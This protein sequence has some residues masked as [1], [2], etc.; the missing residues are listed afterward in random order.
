MALGRDRCRASVGAVHLPSFGIRGHLGELTDKP[1]HSL[2]GQL[3]FTWGHW[4]W[5]TGTPTVRWHLGWWAVRGGSQE[6]GQL[7]R[8]Q[9]RGREGAGSLGLDREQ[10]KVGSFQ[11]G[12]EE[13]SECWAQRPL[14]EDSA[15]P[16][17]PVFVW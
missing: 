12:R 13:P 15:T 7:Q 1:R 16:L 2:G 6:E 10:L 8:G 3:G 9:R 14:P 11:V 4:P 5:G 17:P